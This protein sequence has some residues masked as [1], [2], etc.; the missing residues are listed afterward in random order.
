MSEVL[1]AVLSLVAGR[2]S[3]RFSSA[4]S[5]GR[6]VKELLPSSQRS[7]FPA[8]CFCDL[9]LPWPDFTVSVTII[10]S[11]CCSV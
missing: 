1:R 3:V 9:P 10:T 4:G 8:A 11:G 2:V 5:G 7:G 6:F